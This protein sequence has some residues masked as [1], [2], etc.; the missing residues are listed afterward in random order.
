MTTDKEEQAT[1]IREVTSLR[2]RVSELETQA[3]EYEQN[4]EALQKGEERFRKIF[5]HSNDAIF[6]EG[7]SSICWRIALDAAGMSVSVTVPIVCVMVSSPDS[8]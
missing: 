7:D 6:V 4:E 8:Y 5:E 1:L 3:S 2:A